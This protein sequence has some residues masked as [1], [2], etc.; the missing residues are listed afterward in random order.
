M[1]EIVA[2]PPKIRLSLLNQGISKNDMSQ[3]LRGHP[4]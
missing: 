1:D 2:R 4:K 3:T